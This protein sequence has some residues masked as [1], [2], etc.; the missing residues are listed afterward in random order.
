M[1]STEST[2]RTS[3]NNSPDKFTQTIPN[4]PLRKKQTY[5]N[6]TH[7]KLLMKPLITLTIQLINYNPQESFKRILN[8][9]L[10]QKTN[11]NNNWDIQQLNVNEKKWSNVNDALGKNGT[12]HNSV[13]H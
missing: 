10:I 13:I 7:D 1:Q 5:L 2:V 9:K 6:M 12:D 8:D 3:D 11:D 4:R